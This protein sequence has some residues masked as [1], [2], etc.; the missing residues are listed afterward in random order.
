MAE[1]RSRVPELNAARAAELR[2][3][4]DVRERM[5][6]AIVRYREALEQRARITA[7]LAQDAR[8]AAEVSLSTFRTI[9]DVA[10]LG[11]VLD[12]SLAEFNEISK[13]RAPDFLPI[14]DGAVSD[15][16][17][18]LSRQLEAGS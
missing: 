16:F 17:L 5:A 8:E 6:V 15:Q 7:Q 3:N 1:I 4:L 12:N 10:R 18:E 13:L 11:G 9:E 2:A 14:D